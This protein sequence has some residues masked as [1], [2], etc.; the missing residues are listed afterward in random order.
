MTNTATERSRLEYSA[1]VTFAAGVALIQFNVRAEIL[2][3]LAAIQWAV[4]AWRERRWP[5]A[6]AFFTPLLALAAVTLVSAAV[7]GDPLTSFA[8]SRQLLLYLLVPMTLRIARGPRATRVLDAIIALGAAAAFVGIIQYLATTTLDELLNHRPHGLLNHYM[9]FSGVLMLVTCA[10]VARL[11]YTER[12]WLWP[13]VAIP[14]LLVALAATLSR[15]V[16]VGTAVALA[17]L[18]ATRRRVLLLV[19]PLALVVGMAIAPASVRARLTSIFDPNEPSN[20]DRVAMLK[21]GAAMVKDHPLLGVGPNMVPR[22]YL[23]Y[24]TADAY[25]SAGATAPETRSHVHNVP[26]QLAAERG[27][28]ALGCW[29][30]FVVVAARELFTRMQRGP[31]RGL[32]AAGFAALVAMVAAGLFE[33]NFGDSEFLILML[34]MLSLP[35]AAERSETTA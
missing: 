13:A 17:V 19:L 2:L 32:A 25:D 26:M 23:Q 12:E 28:I 20:R 22:V 24:R 16:W 4:V 31:A 27:V 8:R 1:Y 6:P 29:L 34:V 11:L 18:L 7:S 5:E 14:A 33:H 3:G 35:F 21:A 30:W 10:A 15:N 9:T